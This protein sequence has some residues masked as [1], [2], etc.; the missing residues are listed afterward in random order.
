MILELFILTTHF[1]VTFCLF[2]LAQCFTKATQVVAGRDCYSIVVG[3]VL[4]GLLLA[5][6]EGLFVEGLL[7]EEEGRGEGG[8]KGGE[9]REGERGGGGREGE[10]REGER[11][12][13]GR[14]GEGKEGE[15]GR[16]GGSGVEMVKGRNS[17]EER[18]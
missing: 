12:G 9:G 8:S 18:L 14:E 6:V 16:E 10:G 1:V 2:E 15:R 4:N 5:S 3:L 7:E 17:K 11:G 13:G